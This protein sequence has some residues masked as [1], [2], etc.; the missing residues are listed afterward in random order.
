[1]LLNKRISIFTF[2]KQIKF[3]ITA[4]LIYAIVVG[5]ADQYGFLSKIEIP[6]AMSAIIGTALSL[7]LAFRTAQAYERWWEAR[8]I[9]G[10]IVNDSR[11][12][13]RQVKQF[14]P[15]KDTKIV[16]DFAYRQ[17]I[18]CY[19]LGESLRKLSYSKKVYD[20][21]KEHKL[22]KNNIPNAIINQHSEALSK[23]EISDFKQIQ[24]DS[25]LSRL[26]D[27]MGKC[28]RIK[29]TVFP[30]SYS[31]LVHFFIYVFATLLPFGLDDKYVLVEIF[32]TA[33]IPIIFIAIER[34][35]II[36]QDPFENVTTDIPM[37]SL[38]ITI[39]INIKELIGDTDLPIVEKPKSFYIM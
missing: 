8:I 32:L 37:T 30:K 38:A 17:I 6:I 21:V 35:A 24:I 29:N 14:L 18:W 12:L 34:T 7:L 15:E 1:M 11:T 19:V 16:Q 22:S 2:L 36:L 27:S 10:A 26:C 4:I 3:D 5:I 23:L 25:T 20:Y 13:I 33:L 28:E 31:L 39:E 9:W